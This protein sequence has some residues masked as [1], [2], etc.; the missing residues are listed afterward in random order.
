MKLRCV[1]SMSKSN[2]QCK[3]SRRRLRCG[4]FIVVLFVILLSLNQTAE[5]TDWSDNFDD[6]DISDWTEYSGSFSAASNYLECISSGMI[7]KTSTNTNGSWLFDLWE[8]YWLGVEQH[9]FFMSTHLESN[10]THGYSISL[11]YGGDSNITLYRWINDTRT[12]LGR[13]SIYN[14]TQC[15]SY[16]NVSRTSDGYFEVKR[17]GTVYI[18]VTDNAINQS[19]YFV[20]E[21]FGA[22]RGLDN[23]V[24]FQLPIV[25]PTTTTTGP[26]NTTTTTIIPPDSDSEILEQV[27]TIVVAS[28]IYVGVPAAI[29]ETTLNAAIST[30]YQIRPRFSSVN[31]AR[32]NKTVTMDYWTTR[33][34]NKKFHLTI[35]IH[36]ESANL[37]LHQHQKKILKVGPDNQQLE[38]GEFPDKSEI[39]I[40]VFCDIFDFDINTQYVTISKDQEIASR[41]FSATPRRVGTAS[42]RVE[43]HVVDKTEDK[44]PIGELQTNV[45]VVEPLITVLGRQVPKWILRVVSI[46]PALLSLFLF[47]GSFFFGFDLPSTYAEY[48]ILF[49][50]LVAWIISFIITGLISF[51]V[52]KVIVKELDT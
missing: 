47:T 51:K 6:G 46:S 13:T 12:V 22:G 26:T 41:R 36:N 24:L 7:Y 5:A 50:P 20:Y 2:R 10:T 3:I 21:V 28:F 35:Y 8:D 18:S 29:V 23:V 44:P 49:N 37:K 4:I 14:G 9:V 33:E 19:N 31:I 32:I 52:Y 43:L 30:A 11:E 17:N 40:V 15:W 25:T 45:Q 27:I 16:Y 1:W 39:R 42:L 34:K 38:T 48:A